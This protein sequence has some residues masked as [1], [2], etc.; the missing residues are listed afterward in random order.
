MQK[1]WGKSK[2]G[3]LKPIIIALLRRSPKTGSEIMDEIERLSFG[4]WRPSPGSIYP[5][6]YELEK[7]GLIKKKQ[8]GK[9]ELTAEGREVI[10]PW[11]SRFYA[12]GESLDGLIA[13]IDG[14]VSYLEDIS[15]DHKEELREK[16]KQLQDICKRLERLT[17]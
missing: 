13:E 17:R 14:Y 10:Y 15:R 12:R 3:W 9:Y 7:E 1:V 8:S 4:W 6:L 16:A 11:E 2:R 5:T